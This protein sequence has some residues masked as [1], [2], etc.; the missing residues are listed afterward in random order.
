[1]DTKREKH[2]GRHNETLPSATSNSE[3]VMHDQKIG[4][5]RQLNYVVRLANL[6]VTLGRVAKKRVLP[7]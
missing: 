2:G 3:Q 4:C 7:D 5:R 1:M 6:E